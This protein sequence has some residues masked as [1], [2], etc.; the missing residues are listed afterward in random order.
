MMQH[1]ATITT[2]NYLGKLLALYDSM[3]Q[4]CKPF[5]LYV[6]VFDIVSHD[7]LEKLD[8]PEVRVLPLRTILTPELEAAA[9]RQYPHQFIWTCK[10][11]FL[12]HLLQELEEPRIAYIDADQFFFSSPD[13][14]F[15]EIGANSIGMTQH[16]FSPTYAHCACNGKY[17]GGFLYLRRN[18]FVMETLLPEWIDLC[19]QGAEGPL[20]DQLTLSRWPDR[21]AHR[22]GVHTIKHR[23]MNVGPWNQ[24]GYTMNMR[25]GWLYAANYPVVTYHFHGGADDVGQF[26]EPI[27]PILVTHGYEPYR[28]ALMDASIKLAVL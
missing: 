28:A 12:L 14:I 19:I 11:P 21:F 5:T 16:H 27:A 23:G 3:T 18:K 25:N 15:V 17:N 22:I 24:G 10:G 8:L 9:E 6:L 2:A 1:Y 7:V 13:L 20:T 26:L 4:H